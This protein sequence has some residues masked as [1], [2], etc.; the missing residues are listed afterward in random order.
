MMHARHPSGAR[1]WILVLAALFALMPMLAAAQDDTA[2]K[3]VASVWHMWPKAGQEAQFEQA[4][5][6]HGAWRKQAGEGFK[7][8]VYQPV[9]GADMA[10][11]VVYS[12]QHAWADFDANRKW[13]MDSKSGEA[14]NRGVG[15]YLERYSHYFEDDETDLS[16]WNAD[17]QF[18]MYEVTTM[19]FSPGQYG[20]FRREV[21][22]LR[23]AATAQK[24]SGNWSLASITGGDD[25]MTLVIPL[26]SY[27]DM[28]GPT[29]SIMEMMAKQMGG[30]DQ[31]MKTMTGIQS[32][33]AAGNTTVYAH[34]PDLSTPAD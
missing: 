5:K 3:T 34:R 21:T 18:P 33:I 4:L 15:P 1:A 16:Y 28:A 9:A 13:E 27:A 20:N 29:P 22:A 24:W 11:Y 25:D 30:M 10:Y 17:G 32:A 14:F 12:G 6:E 26:R 31:A 7:W 19:K 2:G 8:E 23:D